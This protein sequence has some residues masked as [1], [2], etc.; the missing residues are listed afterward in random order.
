MNHVCILLHGIKCDPANR[1]WNEETEIRYQN[2][3]SI[4]LISRKYG[5]VSGIS[6]WVNAFKR[7]EVVDH[8]EAYFRG[9][10]NVQDGLLSSLEPGTKVSI[11]G[12]SLGG[13]ITT[14]LLKRGIQFYRIAHLWGSS[15]EGFDWGAVDKNFDRARVY[16]SPNDEILTASSIG[17]GEDPELGLGLMGKVGP[18]VAHPRVESIETDWTHTQFMD[19]TAEQDKF[20]RD[21]FGWMAE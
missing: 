5:Y 19:A 11:A 10:P 1:L 21:I 14:A 6:V 16:W 12:H 7:R 13:Y 2:S 17:A 9:I 20:W 15:V 8:E 3:T 4:R 18:Q